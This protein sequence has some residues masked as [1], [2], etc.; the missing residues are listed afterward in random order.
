MSEVEEEEP[1]LASRAL[2]GSGA[3][4]TFSDGLSDRFLDFFAVSIGATIGQMSFLTAAR[5]LSRHMLQLIWGGLIDRYGKRAFISAGRL[6]NGVLLL[7]LVFVETPVE[8]IPLVIGSS[9]CLSLTIPS[10]SSLLGDYT[11]FLMRGE[12]IGRINAL[13]QTGSL[14][15]VIFTFVL[16]VFQPAETSSR[17]FRLIIAVAAFTSMLSGLLIIY[18]NEKKADRTG[19]RPG[20][21]PA[22]GDERLNR[23]L[24]LNFLFGISISLSWPVFPF[25]VVDKLGMSIWQISATSICSAVSSLLSQRYLSALMD[26]LGRRPIIIL[27][28]LT[29]SLGLPF[30]IFSTSW[31]HIL[32]GE[33]VLGLAW[34][35][36]MSSES[37]YLI[38]LAPR[39]KRATYIATNMAVFGLSFFL[40]SLTGGYITGNLLPAGGS[41]KG[42]NTMLMISMSLR[43]ITGLG[44]TKIFETSTRR[45][46]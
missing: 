41:F 28:R 43:L 1:L 2:F 21:S 4:Q 24:I 19:K 42:I 45:R 31:I 7:A 30:F 13:S 25:I 34:G 29:T 10:W 14:A 33:L 17:L 27:S 23:Y 16:S 35:T 22:L 3:V 15:A 32:M 44:Y 6:L 38:D 5:G 8:L 26:R 9:I 11:V 46:E 37:T 39:E 20:F 18:T 12:F 40:G 36:W